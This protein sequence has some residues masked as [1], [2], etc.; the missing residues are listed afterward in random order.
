MTKKALIFTKRVLPRSNTFVAAQGTNLPSIK[1]VF[2]G[3][4]K[5]SSG[6]DLIKDYSTCVLEEYDKHPTWSKFLL[7]GLGYLSPNWHSALAAQNAQ[8]I[9]AHF[10]KGGYYCA[11]LAKKLQ[12]PLLTTVQ[13]SDITQQDKFSYGTRHRKVVF[14]HSEKILAVS[15]FI[16]NKLIERGCP[17]HKIIQHYIGIDSFNFFYAI[18]QSFIKELNALVPRNMIV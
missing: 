12:L 8:L 7:E 17:E 15:E 6:I 4:T 18:F 2:I 3:F 9:H 13:G 14:E 16:K 1:P 11:T 10:G 5:D